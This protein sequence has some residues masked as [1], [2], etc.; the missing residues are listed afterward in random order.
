MGGV[1]NAGEPNYRKQPR[2]FDL[3]GPREPSIP[4]LLPSAQSTHASASLA[5]QPGARRNMFDSDWVVNASSFI[6]LY[7]NWMDGVPVERRRQASDGRVRSN[8]SL[9]LRVWPTSQSLCWL[10]QGCNYVLSSAHSD[11]R[12]RDSGLASRF[13]TQEERR[14]PCFNCAL[15]SLL[16]RP[17]NGWVPWH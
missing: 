5:G 7:K 3:V 4:V 17:N 13:R 14:F 16:Y 11:K 15:P 10:R 9:L 6:L 1:C 12:G 2:L 8:I